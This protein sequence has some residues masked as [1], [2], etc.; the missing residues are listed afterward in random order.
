MADLTLDELWGSTPAAGAEVAPSAPAPG[1]S[2]DE[3]WDSTPAT[4][5]GLNAI[6]GQIG[7]GTALGWFDEIQGAE[8]GLQQMLANV[9]GRGN[10]KSFS[11]N[12]DSLT[13]DLRKRDDAYEEANPWTSGALQLGGAIV[14]SVVSGGAGM[15]AGGE[16]VA[17]KTLMGRAGQ[18]IARSTFGA[19]IEGTPS[20]GQ[21]VRMGAAGG[22]VYGAGEADEGSR[23]VGGLTGAG[24]GMLAA[25]VAGKAIE[26]GGN[27]LAD[28]AANYGMSTASV[29]KLLGRLKAD[30][31]G[32]FSFDPVDPS[33]GYTPDELFLASQ[34]KNTPPEKLR[35][36]LVEM[37]TAAAKGSPLFLPEAIGS[38]KV[39]RNARFIANHDASIEFSK[40]A[41]DERT[42]G[43]QKRAMALFDQV[44][45]EK[46]SFDGA[47]KMVDASKRILEDAK[48]ARKKEVDPLY[49]QAY[50]DRPI[51]A[52][53]ELPEFIKADKTLQSAIRDVQK[54]HEYSGLPENS[55]RLLVAARGELGDQMGLAAGDSERARIVSTYNKLNSFLHKSGEGDS[56]VMAD[57]TFRNLTGGLDELNESFLA[58]LTRIS[59][60]KID[61]VGKIFEL[62]AERVAL[63]RDT[64]VKKGMLDEWNAGIRAYMQNTVNGTKDGSNFVNKL[65][66]TTLD[67][68]IMRAALGDSYE[69]V[70][71]GLSLESRMFEGKNKYNAGS[72]TAGNLAEEREYRKAL[73]FLGKMGNQDYLGA[74]A[75]MLGVGDLPAET[76]QRLARIYFD[77]S[78]GAGRGALEKIMPLL[79]QYG[80]NQAGAIAAGKTTG[81]GSARLGGRLGASSAG[82]KIESST[83]MPSLLGEGQ[84]QAPQGQA[85]RG[86]LSSP[87]TPG[88]LESSSLQP[89]PRAGAAGLFQNS[90]ANG[91]ASLDLRPIL[92]TTQAS[93]PSL[94]STVL[95]PTSK[96]APSLMQAVLGG[97]MDAKQVE[98]VRQIDQ[99]P[100]DSAIFEVESSRGKNLKNP[101][102][103]ASGPFQLIA[104]TAKT[105]GADATDA[106]WT[107]DFAAYKKLRAEN[108]ARFGSDPAVLYAAHYL[109]ATLLAKWQAGKSL[110][111]DDEAL[112]R[113]LKQKALPNFMK[114]YER[115]L[116]DK[117]GSVEA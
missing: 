61:G 43:A 97:K 71:K 114:I 11:E 2:F 34:L 10:G 68:D 98:V 105:L 21:L 109:G 15:L 6:A 24:V 40:V 77:P 76:A 115:I 96:N 103:S 67:K 20:V 1:I 72:T 83:T 88:S 35:A 78:S 18:E 70:A 102:S 110:S 60:N 47:K 27:A 82:G 8:Y 58:N 63:L 46:S 94:F 54:S 56:L 30:E 90:S 99:D 86:A 49:D 26:I 50:K 22:G 106:D 5:T 9:L 28:L 116:A 37:N 13:G 73:T 25:P 85:A 95:S 65:T 111:S 91:G 93:K 31:R 19:G 14:P 12:Y 74:F 66:G 57:A 23:L 69:E 117:S 29:S 87:S 104:K 55:T 45:P 3:L 108:E 62:P 92:A 42:G 100:I 107:D 52:D 36:A 38:P 75:H 89:Q 48:T 41:I 59:D 4:P 33:R 112:V 51:I 101:D 79:E 7:K 39:D 64:F 32:S 80:R 44:S 53:P 16:N 113:S 84:S 81:L 17:A